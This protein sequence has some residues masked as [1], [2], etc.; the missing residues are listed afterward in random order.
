GSAG[1]TYIDQSEIIEQKYP[2]VVHEMRIRPDSEGAGRQRGA[3]GG[4]CIY[5]PL[6]D[7]PEVHYSMDGMHNLP[8]GV[9]A[10]GPAAGNRACRV[11]ADGS[12]RELPEIVGEVVVQP[13][14]RMVSLSAGGGGYG[15]PLTRPVEAVLADVVDGYVSVERAREAYC[16]AIA[17]DSERV[18]T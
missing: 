16:V 9:Q 7:P 14:E 18:E 17:G 1:L 12:S 15:D 3:P 13:G 6:H 8:Q 11:A 10:G 2:I 4:I 5:G